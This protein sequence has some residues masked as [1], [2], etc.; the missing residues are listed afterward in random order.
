MVRH[1][2]SVA[3]ENK[4][5]RMEALKA[6]VNIAMQNC[7]TTLHKHTHTLVILFIFFDYYYRNAYD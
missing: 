3:V 6:N 2:G 1:S 4:R 5:S 7:R